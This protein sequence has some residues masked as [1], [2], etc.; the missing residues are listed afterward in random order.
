M[1]ISFNSNPYILVRGKFNKDE[2]IDLSISLNI[3]TNSELVR[4]LC[5]SYIE[6]EKLGDDYKKEEKE[7]N[8]A[9]IKLKEMVNSKGW[10]LLEK[11]RKFY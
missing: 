3:L 1:K 2:K 10:R 5:D 6:Y 9:K 7:L 8:N 4:M 11:F